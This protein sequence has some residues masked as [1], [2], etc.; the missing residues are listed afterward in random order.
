MTP[1][2]V[3]TRLRDEAL[4]LMDGRGAILDA[5]LTRLHLHLTGAPLVGRRT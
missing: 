5:A 2:L 3:E 1:L 4:N